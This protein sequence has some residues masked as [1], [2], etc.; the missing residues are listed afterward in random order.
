MQLT[1]NHTTCR[2]T[3]V[4]PTVHLS[5]IW[6]CSF[7]LLHVGE[8]TQCGISINVV[9]LW[10]LKLLNQ[11]DILELSPFNIFPTCSELQR[12]HFNWCVIC[13]TV[14]VTGTLHF[15]CWKSTQEQILISLATDFLDYCPSHIFGPSESHPLGKPCTAGCQARD[16][17]KLWVWLLTEIIPLLGTDESL[18]SDIMLTTWISPWKRQN[19]TRHALQTDSIKTSL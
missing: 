19:P 11:G 13:S 18:L 4:L 1:H 9:H 17:A 16:I 8:M 3:S 2:E 15:K 6:R 5:R 12:A 14:P 10:L 7:D